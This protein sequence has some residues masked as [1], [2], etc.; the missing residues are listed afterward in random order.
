MVAALPILLLLLAHAPSAH[1]LDGSVYCSRDGET[2]RL[3]GFGAV[4]PVWSPDGETICYV[5]HTHDE[6]LFHFISPAGEL[7]QTV[8]LPAPLTVA[9][10]LTWHPDGEVTFAA[11]QGESY[12][13]YKLDSEGQAELIMSD[14]I[15]PAWSPDGQ[16]MAFTTYRDSN[17][18]I[19]L[20]DHEGRLRNLSRHESSDARSSWAPDGIR[21]A[22]ESDRFGNLD[23]CVVEVASGDIRRLTNHPGKDWNPVWS[24]D[25]RT[26]AFVSSRYGDNQIY[27]M[28]ADGTDV[29]RF[30]QGHAGDWQLAWSPD[31]KCLC[32]VSS[33]PEPFFDWLIRL[34]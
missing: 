10:D 9:A 25:G 17:L 22:F 34:F 5:Q 16:S 26:I 21:I 28:N 2:R 13:I 30:P 1:D 11:S 14:G 23:I 20:A 12:D 6:N 27:I 7:L 4:A 24:P 15:Q 32:F 19:Y 18:E 31:G 3:S 8:P 29:R 33:R